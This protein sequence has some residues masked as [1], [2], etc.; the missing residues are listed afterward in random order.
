MNFIKITK[1]ALLAFS[2]VALF[3]LNAD[4]QRIATVD[5]NE[6][7]E[8]MDDYKIAQKQLDDT[9]ARWRRQIS[10]EYDKIKGLYNK[11]QAEQVLLSDDM[12][13][14][15]EE[16]IMN[17]EKEVREMQKAKFGPEGALFVK[18]K[19]LVEPIQER[20]YNTIEAYAN[21]KGYDFI[22][23]Q[24]GSAGIIFANARYDKTEDILKELGAGK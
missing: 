19:E 23:D 1:T 8:N 22:F 6:V 13:L 2:L 3:S 15:K 9:A 5:I 4:A 11:Y 18:R 17:K 16:E 14:Q 20:V 24:S 12:R 21:D 7:L 10:E